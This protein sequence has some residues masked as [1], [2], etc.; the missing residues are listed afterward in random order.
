M[1]QLC[2]KKYLLSLCHHLVSDHLSPSGLVISRYSFQFPMASTCISVSDGFSAV[3]EGR[4]GSSA[5]EWAPGQ[6]TVGAGTGEGPS[7]LQTGSP[8][9]LGV[10]PELIFLFLSNTKMA[11][12]KSRENSITNCS[13]PPTQLLRTVNKPVFIFCSF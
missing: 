9:V 2:L 13:V 6:S 7:T 4:Q 11:K 12:N 10:E 5:Q 8:L 3:R 1:F